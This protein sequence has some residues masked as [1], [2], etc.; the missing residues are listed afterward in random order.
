MNRNIDIIRGDV[1]M[2]DLSPTVGSEQGGYRPCV[3]IQNNLGNRFSPTIQ[4]AAITTQIHKAKLP[5]H[6]EV[7]A[8]QVG[9]EKD[10]VI[11]LEQTRTIDKKRLSK[12]VARLDNETMDR[13]YWAYMISCASDELMKQMMQ[14]R[15]HK[16]KSMRL[17]VV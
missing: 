17:A 16:N 10:S 2:I 5:T 12:W 13:V 6:V 1:F 11:M 8:K 7:S 15:E 9:L 3:V 14:E 4:V